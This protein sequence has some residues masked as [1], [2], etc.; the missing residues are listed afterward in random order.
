MNCDKPVFLVRKAISV[1]LE[2]AKGHYNPD[3]RLNVVSKTDTT[4]L[5]VSDG[6]PPTHS[7]TRTYPGDDP[8][9]FKRTGR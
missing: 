7:K 8:R 2:D 1:K 4:P 3:L 6:A 9:N 5:V